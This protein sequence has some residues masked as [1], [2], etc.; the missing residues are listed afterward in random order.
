MAER[1][2]EE[3]KETRE[4]EKKTIFKQNPEAIGQKPT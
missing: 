2:P 3:K 1:E 4:K